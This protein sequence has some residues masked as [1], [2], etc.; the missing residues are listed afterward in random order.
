MPW[1][2]DRDFSEIKMERWN[3]PP[4]IIAVIE[5]PEQLK[6]VIDMYNDLESDLTNTEKEL[7]GARAYNESLSNTWKK[8]VLDR[9]ELNSKLAKAVT[10]LEQIAANTYG[11]ELCNTE[12]EN[13]AIT[14]GHFF[15]HQQLARNILAELKKVE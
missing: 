7:E 14:A 9:A 6:R 5:D 12:E 4:A 15:H 2:K 13:N 3:E 1:Y 8:S 11:T 10:V